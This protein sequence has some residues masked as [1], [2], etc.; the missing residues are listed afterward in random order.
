MILFLTVLIIIFIFTCGYSV[1][2]LF[3]LQIKSLIEKFSYSWGLGVGLVS[4]QLFFYSLLTIEWTKFTLVTPWLAIILF[5]FWKNKPKFVLNKEKFDKT[6]R[7]F[8]ILIILLLGFTAFEAILRPVQAWDGW[9]NWLLRPKVFFLNNNISLDYVRYTTDGYPLIIPLMST[10]YY[11][12]IG[13]V[14]DKNVL[15]LFFTFYL[16]IAGL[17]YAKSKEMVGRKIALIFTFLLISTQNLIR[18]GGRYEAGHADLALSYFILAVACL[19]INYLK[20]KTLKN[21]LLFNIILG[22]S[23]L[24]K[25]DGIPIFLIGNFLTLFY[26]IKSRKFIN[27]VSLMP[28]ILLFGSWNLYKHLNDYPKNWIAGSGSFHYDKIGQIVIAM[29]KEFFNFQNWSLLFIVFIF[30]LIIYYKNIKKIFPVFLLLLVQFF[31]YVL[32]FMLSPFA[33]PVDH[34]A[35]VVNR[36]YIHIAPLAL[37]T[38]VALISVKSFSEEK[39]DKKNK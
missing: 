3:N 15:L 35:G 4:T 33:N 28:S 25:N 22:F 31:F 9:L 18:H 38:T 10:F 13:Q 8:L 6:E 7:F 34:V 17:F 26:I 1:V 5:S 39:H 36:L 2:N 27:I 16:T 37:L 12:L 14:N 30:T 20:S 23:A 19:L 29:S 11:K 32:A 21:L 24:I